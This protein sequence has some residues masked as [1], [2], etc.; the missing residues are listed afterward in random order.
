MSSQQVRFLVLA[1]VA[2]AIVAAAS[3]PTALDRNLE[4]LRSMPH[5]ERILLARALDEFEKLGPED[6]AAIEKIDRQIQALDPTARSNYLNTLRRYHLWL[7]RLSAADRAKIADAP[8]D[9]ARFAIVEKLRKTTPSTSS[10]VRTP[11]QLG[12]PIGDI[13]SIAPIELGNLIR[14]WFALDDRERAR[15]ESF[16]VVRRIAE[17]SAIGFQRRIEVRRLPE[18]DQFAARKEL[19]ELPLYKSLLANIRGRQDKSKLDSKVGGLLKKKLENRPQVLANPL[20]H[21]VE[22]HYFVQH[23]P[24]RVE[25]SN[26]A[27]FAAALP[28]WVKDSI[29]PLPAEEA[30]RRLTI[31]YREIYP[32]PQEMP[33]PTKQTEVP[34]PPSPGRPPGA[35]KPPQPF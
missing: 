11:G 8:D 13:G 33:K 9:A 29:D 4:R 31:L 3:T 21:L 22:S 26:L 2:V 5:E 14:V 24:I 18:A 34:A 10:L 28:S 7:S 17:L 20:N 16:P 12:V 1:G 19:E 32:H 30:R 15:I 35:E 25:P 27:R 23:P 6:R